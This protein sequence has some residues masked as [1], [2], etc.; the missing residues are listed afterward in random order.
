MIILV[1]QYPGI[2]VPEY[3]LFTDLYIP[4][5]RLSGCP[6]TGVTGTF[7]TPDTRVQL[8]VLM[9]LPTPLRFVFVEQVWFVFLLC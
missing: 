5:Y 9:I 1:L 2:R 3:I 7:C 6:G 4:G 8:Y